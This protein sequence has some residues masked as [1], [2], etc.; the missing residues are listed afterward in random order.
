M[1][2]NRVRSGSICDYRRRLSLPQAKRRPFVDGEVQRLLG[3]VETSTQ[4]DLRDCALLGPLD[5]MS[6]R[7]GAVVNRKFE[8]LYPSGKRL[9]FRFK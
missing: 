6:S 5:Y 8:D 3:A 4:T 9:F 2:I 1:E 7:I